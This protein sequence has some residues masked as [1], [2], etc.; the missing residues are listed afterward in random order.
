MATPR[1]LAGFLFEDRT[2]SAVD[3]LPRMDIAVFVGFATS[4]PLH[5]PVPIESPDRFR[6]L[7]G[8]DL[9]LA[10]DAHYRRMQIAHLAASV[11]AFFANGGERC[12]VIRVADE[13]KAETSRFAM[14][15]LV[16]CSA[17]GKLSTAQALARS[18]GRGADDLRLT[19]ALL[20]TPV[21]IGSVQGLESGWLALPQVSAHSV[22]VGD[23]L[24]IRFPD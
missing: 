13:T 7:F 11:P 1:R 5:L 17:S 9:P 16:H 18:P 20:S 24:R 19:T 21:V 10:W 23:L 22:N 6:D 15:S 3:V 8:G 2:P 14:P 4:G 12:W